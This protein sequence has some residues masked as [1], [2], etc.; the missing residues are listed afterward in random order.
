MTGAVEDLEIE[1]YEFEGELVF[2]GEI[3]GFVRLE[4]FWKLDQVSSSIDF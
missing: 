1:N 3:A 4:T 2:R